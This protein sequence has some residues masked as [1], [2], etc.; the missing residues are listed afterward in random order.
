MHHQMLWNWRAIN[1]INVN[2]VNDSSTLFLWLLKSEQNGRS[3]REFAY[4][5]S[6]ITIWHSVTYFDDCSHF[7]FTTVPLML[8]VFSSTS[9]SA[10]VAVFACLQF[11][12]L[13]VGLSLSF[14]LWLSDRNVFSFFLVRFAHHQNRTRD[15]FIFIASHFFECSTMIANLACTL[16]KY[17]FHSLFVDGVI[18]AGVSKHKAKIK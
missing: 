9:R 16:L 6:L 5:R 8:F 7:S 18:V 1:N 4:F 10:S 12:F 14:L 11:N 17:L 3:Q 13:F 2:F 15:Y